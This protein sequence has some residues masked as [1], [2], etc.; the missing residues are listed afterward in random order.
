MME[1]PDTKNGEIANLLLA[2]SMRI[3]TAIAVAHDI[4]APE[5]I[6]GD[7]KPDDSKPDDARDYLGRFLLLAQ[8]M[9]ARAAYLSECVRLIHNRLVIS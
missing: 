2:T 9:D 7:S 8:G 3:D 1:E 5:G 6:L 4:M